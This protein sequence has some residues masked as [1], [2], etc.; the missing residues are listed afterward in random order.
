MRRLLYAVMAAV[1][2]VG[3]F[4][5]SDNDGPK[6]I[7]QQEQERLDSIRR[8][9][10]I[11][12]ALKAYNDSMNGVKEVSLPILKYGMSFDDLVAQETRTLLYDTTWTI[13]GSLGGD[14]WKMTRRELDYAETRPNAV[15]FQVMYLFGEN[16]LTDGYMAVWRDRGKQLYEFMRWGFFSMGSDGGKDYFISKDS[17]DFIYIR[18]MYTINPTYDYYFVNFR[19]TSPE[20]IKYFYASP[21]KRLPF[22]PRELKA[23]REMLQRM[24]FRTAKLNN[25]PK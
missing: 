24:A 25:N 10:S 16:E 6:G 21:S 5:C 18:D 15:S 13:E 19:E 8:A 3:M 7:S 2:L 14:D 20:E 22:N 17:T 1:P 23:D 9:D 12:A 11:A 4:A